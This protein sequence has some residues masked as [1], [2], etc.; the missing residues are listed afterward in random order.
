MKLRN[1]PVSGKFTLS[2]FFRENEG[3]CS[4]TVSI[5]SDA[6]VLIESPD[7]SSGSLYHRF[8]KTLSGL[9]RALECMK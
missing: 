2:K 5:E 9:L 7:W 1:A 8:P 6:V 3:G 4:C